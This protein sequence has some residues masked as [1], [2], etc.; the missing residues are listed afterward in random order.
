MKAKLI[1]QIVGS[2]FTGFVGS[3]FI[4]AAITSTD[5]EV[6]RRIVLGGLA[7]TITA[8]MQWMIWAPRDM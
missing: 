1:I 6:W 5:E 2:A 4:Y 3:S 7:G 8:V